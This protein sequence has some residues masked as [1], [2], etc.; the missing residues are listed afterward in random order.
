VKDSNHRL[1]SFLLEINIENYDFSIFKV[2]ST[3]RQEFLFYSTIPFVCLSLQI[4]EHQSL[5]SRGNKKSLFP[6]AILL[7]F[8]VHHNKCN[9]GKSNTW[10]YYFGKL[11]SILGHPKMGK[12]GKQK[13]QSST[14]YCQDKVKDLTRPACSGKQELCSFKGQLCL[15]S[16]VMKER[17]K[18]I[19]SKFLSQVTL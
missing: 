3:S 4:S 13:D 2:S 14:K 9:L 7:L 1:S 8:G 16:K 17:E 11:I 12:R 19:S 6:K 15:A 18:W 10:K 5:L